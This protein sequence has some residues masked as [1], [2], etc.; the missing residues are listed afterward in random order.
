MEKCFLMKQWRRSLSQERWRQGRREGER[1]VCTYISI[2]SGTGNTVRE[3]NNLKNT[4][5]V[6]EIEGYPGSSGV[7]N[8]LAN[9]G[10][11]G[12]IPVS[13]RSPGE[14]NGNPLQYFC[15]GSPRNRGDWQLQSMGSQRVWHY[16]A[17]ETMTTGQRYTRYNKWWWEFGLKIE[18]L[19][20]ICFSKSMTTKGVKEDKLG[21]WDE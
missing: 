2:G 17:T 10:D 4:G 13:G 7:K 20:K 5:E 21:V 15:L 11:M 8:L 19:I 9:V 18:E 14:G 12:F 3:N 1:G 6:Q 16:R